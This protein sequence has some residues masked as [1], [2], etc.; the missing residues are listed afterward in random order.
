[1]HLINAPLPI[2]LQGPNALRV[3]QDLGVFDQILSRSG[4]LHPTMGPF[5]YLSGSG[6]H[7]E[8]FDVHMLS[9]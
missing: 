9:R 5:L 3:V 4:E 2:N 7:R 6:D 8:L 1:L